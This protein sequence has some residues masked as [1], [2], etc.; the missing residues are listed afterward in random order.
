MKRIFTIICALLS[1]STQAQYGYYSVMANAKVQKSPASITLNWT[2]PP[3]V[4]GGQTMI[5][6]KLKTATSWAAPIAILNGNISSYTDNNVV[7]GTAYEYRI[8]K[9]DT[10]QPYGYIY[11][12]IEEGPIHLRGAILLLIDST[13]SD[14]CRT[15]INT[16]ITDLRGDGWEVLTKTFE[17]TE[18]VANVKNYIV[19]TYNS[20]SKLS[21]IY[22]LGHIAVP[23]SGSLNPD[24]HNNHIGAWPADVYYGDMNGNWTDNTVNNVS[25]ANPLNHNTPGDG[26]FDNDYIASDIEL[27]VGRVDFWDM[28]AFSASEIQLMRSY[29]N[30]AHAYKTGALTVIK[31]ALI[32]DNFKNM[33]EGFAGNGWRN[34]APMVG[35][36]SV[37]EKDFIP[38]LNNNFYQWAYG[39]GGGSYTSCSGIGNTTNIAANNMNAI[40]TPLF[41]SYFGDWNY[42]NNF[43]RAPLCADEPSLA[44]FW[45]GRPNWHL[46]HMALGENIG[47]ATRLTQNNGG[48]YITPISQ[49]SKMVTIALMGD[50]TLRTEYIKA[51]GS[52]TLTPTT[53]AGAVLSWTASAEPGVAGYYI[54]R[55]TSEF[56]EYKLR[57]GIVTGTTFT[58]SFG[59]DG[60]YWY[61]VRATKLQTT[62]SGTY[63]NLSVGIA[64]QG[65]FQFPFF[66]VNVVDI[67]AISD[68]I[69]TPNPAQN[70]TQLHIKSNKS[71]EANIC[72]TDLGGKI[73]SAEQRV[74][75]AGNNVYSLDISKLAA[76]MY[77]V[78][79]R[80]TEGATTIKLAKTY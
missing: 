33:Q 78:H 18:T 74:L 47:Y 11:A 54:Y 14:S 19:N 5:Y 40:F 17:R 28:P 6:R 16:L 50:P 37:S 45:A 22:I 51:P 71:M 66:D 59:T 8:Q 60:T 79:V 12:G 35:I 10:T 69:I 56:G 75:Q 64:D 46:H 3:A 1:I 9:D 13:F 61:M 39:C 80:S 30:K 67:K 26:K 34:F 65:T 42:K 31:R 27:Q 32:D 76:G 57:S 29:L 43:L 68:V 52:I 38:T 20:N 53:G 36:D 15:E 62:P 44:S 7:A 25:S 2:T 24:A 55:S 70:I 21:A 58:D 77:M 41:G 23:Y 63:Y 48:I 4:T 72:I 49:M 73:L